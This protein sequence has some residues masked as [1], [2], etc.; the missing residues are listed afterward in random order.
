MMDDFGKVARS[1]VHSPLTCEVEVVI[2]ST[3]QRCDEDEIA[4]CVR[5]MCLALCLTLG[6]CLRHG[7][8]CYYYRSLRG[9][10]HDLG[11]ILLWFLLMS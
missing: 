2:V 6:M 1:L 11:S 10:G 4:K 5:V 9:A 8:H 3:P 7:S